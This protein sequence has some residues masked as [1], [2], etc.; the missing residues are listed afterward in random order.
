MV[1]SQREK[2][3][4]GNRAEAFVMS[5]LDGS[6]RASGDC[7]LVWRGLRIEVKSA[8]LCIRRSTHGNLRYNSNGFTVSRR[9]KRIHKMWHAFVLMLN[10]EPVLVRFLHSDDFENHLMHYGRQNRM[11][12]RFSV[13][14]DGLSLVDF[15]KL[16][17]DS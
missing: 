8:Q 16:H 10:S 9:L 14:Y 11:R 2:K 4:Y 1:V 13:F 17:G 5:L 3:Q 7:D 12:L 6:A 15:R